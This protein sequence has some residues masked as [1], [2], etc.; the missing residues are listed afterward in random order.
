LLNELL[1]IEAGLSASGFILEGRHPDLQTARKTA[2]VRTR[3]RPDGGLAEIEVLL[4]ET[5]A[6]LWTLRD[7]QQNSF[8]FLQLKRPLLNLP[9]DKNWQKKQAET[10]KTL[11]T[12]ERRRALRALA[13]DPAMGPG[14]GI[15]PRQG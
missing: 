1:A 2:A 15:G 4:P 5:T 11:K 6:K 8:P 13:R 9:D 10:W 3:L 12:V 7:G 14:S